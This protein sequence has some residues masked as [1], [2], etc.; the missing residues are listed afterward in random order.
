MEADRHIR[1]GTLL[2]DLPIQSFNEWGDQGLQLLEEKR[3][4]LEELHLSTNELLDDLSRGEAFYV[5]DGM[6]CEQLE[7]TE[8]FDKIY[9]RYSL[10][11]KRLSPAFMYRSVNLMSVSEVT[12]ARLN[13]QELLQL[14]VQEYQQLLRTQQL[15]ESVWSTLRIRLLSLNVIQRVCYTLYV[16]VELQ[17]AYG[18][19]LYNRIPKYLTHELLAQLT[20][21]SRTRVSYV[22]SD[23]RKKGKVIVSSEGL[24]IEEKW[25]KQEIKNKL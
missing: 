20:C 21:L 9:T 4:I 24:Q 12:V 15:I 25:L 6:V 19:R 5:L 14:P 3:L 22:M 2:L 16:I 13:H 23:L 7:G 8:V 1:T 18:I 17:K 10:I 11:D